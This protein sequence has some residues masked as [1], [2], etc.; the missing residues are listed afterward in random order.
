MT[1]QVSAP[2][3]GSGRTFGVSNASTG[4][5]YIM[6]KYDANTVTQKAFIAPVALRVVG[7]AGVTRVAGSGGACTFSLYKTPD[8]IAV[9]SGTLLHSG[10]YDLVGTADINQYLTLSTDLTALT[11]APGD[12]IGVALTGT[13]TSAVGVL[14]FTLEPV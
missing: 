6:F 5:K 1:T 11:F 14:T 13:P 4:S 2:V 9:A 12:A 7:I 10:T 3:V 8:G